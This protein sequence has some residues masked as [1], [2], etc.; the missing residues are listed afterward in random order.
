MNHL[1]TKRW[2]TLSSDTQAESAL[3]LP[4]TGV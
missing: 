1:P 4:T 3:G 2:R